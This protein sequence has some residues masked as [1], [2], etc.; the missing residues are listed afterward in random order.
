MTDKHEWDTYHMEQVYNGKDTYTWE[1]Q[2]IDSSILDVDTNK[3]HLIY[4]MYY[5]GYQKLLKWT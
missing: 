2:L 4:L 1:K 5:I 3:T